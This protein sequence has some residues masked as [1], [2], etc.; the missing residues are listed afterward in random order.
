MTT[1]RINQVTSVFLRTFE[2][3]F[4]SEISRDATSARGGSLDEGGSLSDSRYRRISQCLPQKVRHSQRP[5]WRQRH[6]ASF[7]GVEIHCAQDTGG[8]NQ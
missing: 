3:N 6:R 1:G 8:E 4:E 7:L 2:V 5:R